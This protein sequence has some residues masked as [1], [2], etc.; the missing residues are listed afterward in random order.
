MKFAANELALERL[1]AIL[2]LSLIL[3][4]F[5]MELR[6]SDDSCVM[7]R[8]EKSICIGIVDR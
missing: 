4:D 7:F 1:V 6:V 3:D 5:W 8:R 2:P